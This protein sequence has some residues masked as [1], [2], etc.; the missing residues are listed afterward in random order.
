MNAIDTTTVHTAKDGRKF[1]HFVKENGNKGVRYIKEEETMKSN[2]NEDKGVCLNSHQHDLCEYLHP[3]NEKC[4]ICDKIIDF[5]TELVEI[6]QDWI[7]GDPVY[8]HTECSM[9]EFTCQFCYGHGCNNCVFTGHITDDFIPDWASPVLLVEN[10]LNA[11]NFARISGFHGKLIKSLLD[12]KLYV[13][14][15]GDLFEIDDPDYK[16]LRPHMRWAGNDFGTY[17]GSAEEEKETIMET[18][19]GIPNTTSGVVCGKCRKDGKDPYYHSTVADVKACYTGIVQDEK[20]VKYFNVKDGGTMVMAKE[21]ARTISTMEG[22]TN[23]SVS[24]TKTGNFAVTWTA[25]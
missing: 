23:V 25:K 5:T 12:S 10:V 15:V 21:Y 14:E 16:S 4:T 19:T 7:T 22:V 11:A 9:T 17:T 2:P 18:I 13:F 24:T 6:E 20:S 8:T 3:V 1:R